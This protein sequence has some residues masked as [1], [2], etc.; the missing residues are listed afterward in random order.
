MVLKI[1]PMGVK[2]DTKLNID[3]G[4]VSQGERRFVYL[5]C[6]LDQY[7]LNSSLAHIIIYKI[8]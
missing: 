3:S 6:Y 7:R 1:L 4:W 2:K 5:N 8:T